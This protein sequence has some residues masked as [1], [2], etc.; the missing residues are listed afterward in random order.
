MSVWF[1][2]ITSRLSRMDPTPHNNMEGHEAEGKILLQL[3]VPNEA[4]MP[5]G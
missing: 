1:R 2:D 4:P 5:Q 3:Q